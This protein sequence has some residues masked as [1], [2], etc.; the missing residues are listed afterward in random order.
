MPETLQQTVSRIT[1]FIQAN[2][3][4]VDIAPGSV[5]S[6]LVLNLESQVQNQLYS[7]I[8]DISNLQSIQSVLSSLTPTY[9]P[10]IDAIASNY[11]VVRNQG[12][13]SSGI[14]KVFVSTP[15]NYT[16][17][18]GTVFTQPT[19]GYTY[20][21]TAATYVTLNGSGNFSGTSLSNAQPLQTEATGYSFI[22]PVTAQAIGQVTVLSNG[23]VFLLST[24]SAISNFISASAFGTFSAGLNQET[25]QQLVTRFRNG[26]GVSNLLSQ[27]SITN[28]LETN[29]SNFQDAYIADTSSPLLTRSKSNPLG[30]KIP[31]CVDVWVKDGVSIPYVTFNVVGTSYSAGVW[32][33]PIPASAAPGFYR[34]DNVTL[35]GAPSTGYLPFNIASYNYNSGPNLLTCAY[36]ARFTVYQTCT[37]NVNYP[38]STPTPTF[39]IQCIAIPDLTAMQGYFL[40]DNTRIPC[41]DYLVKGIVPCMVS[42]NLSLVQ[43]NAGDITPANITALQAAIFNYVNGLGSGEPVAASQIV[44]L[45]HQYPIARVDLPVVLNGT[46]L[47]P[48][49]TPVTP[50]A[51]SGPYNDN[52]IQITGTDYLQIPNLPTQGVMPSNTMFFINYFD[53]YGNPQININ[54]TTQ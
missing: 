25:D 5:F 40:N 34:V 29:F 13:Y 32:T 14:I 44:N 41:S 22:L 35:Q 20:A 37:L 28:F 53:Q 2:A 12:S 48:S 51:T 45:C 39:T 47:A 11:N 19:L 10:I 52:N 43:N 31:G 9:S 54:T 30:Y 42:V 16:I 23:T 6:E 26:L 17:Q 1:A 8:D 3:P 27:N 38:V 21:T 24:N 50:Y 7:D 33:V 49:F 18:T 4:N 36:D 15:G 46:I